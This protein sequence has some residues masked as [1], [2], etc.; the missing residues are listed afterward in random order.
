MPIVDTVARTRCTEMRQTTFVFNA[1]KQQSVSIGQTH[2]SGIE[3]AVYGIR[4]IV[5]V[6]DGIA[7]MAR[8]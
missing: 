3:D 4:P 5:A 6:E 8:E 2:G 1:A 7:G